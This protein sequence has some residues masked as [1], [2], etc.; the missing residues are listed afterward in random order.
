MNEA[1]ENCRM[2]PQ[3]TNDLEASKLQGLM[4]EKSLVTSDMAAYMH[5]NGMPDSRTYLQLRMGA[6]EQILQGLRQLH[7][8]NFVITYAEPK[9]I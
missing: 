5:H 4:L 3:K 7:C 1:L 9:V 8:R 2:A 6:Q